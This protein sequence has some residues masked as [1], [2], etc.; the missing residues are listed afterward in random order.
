VNG[1]LVVS[2]GIS[3]VSVFKCGSIWKVFVAF[4]FVG[5]SVRFHTKANSMCLEGRVRRLTKR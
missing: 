3:D 2:R 5:V 4:A 1:Y